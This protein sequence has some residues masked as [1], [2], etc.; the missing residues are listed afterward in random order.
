LQTR[1][2]LVVLFPRAFGDRH[3]E[4]AHL[5]V[6]KPG[7]ATM[8]TVLVVEKKPVIGSLLRER[9]VSESVSVDCVC[10]IDEAVE[11][12]QEAG[13]DVLI[14]NV[15]ASKTERSKG[16]E[17]LDKLTQNSSRTYI[18]AV[19]DRWASPT[20]LNRIRG[21]AH[22]TLTHPLSGDEIHALVMQAFS[23]EPSSEAMKAPE[24]A[25]PLEF[26]GMLGV[27]LPMQ[28]VF[29]RII[30]AASEDISVLITGETG[31][32][33]DMVAS[34]IHRSSRRAA[35]PYVAVNTGAIPSDLI[36][37]ELFGRER[38]AYTGADESAKGHFEQAHGGT[39][40]LD[41]ISTI[42]EKA[43]VS[44]LRVLESKTF[45]RVGGDKDICANVRVI[46]A[47]NEN[48]EAAV[49]DRRF[50]ED[51][52]YRLDVFHIH[53]PPLRER[54]GGVAL[55]TN[56]FVPH[57][58]AIYKK[59]VR[60]IAPETWPCLRNYSWTGNVRELKNVIQR[61]VLM[62]RG[63][64]LTP[65]LLPLR[66]RGASSMQRTLADKIG[67]IHVGMTLNRVE[68]EFIVMTLTATQG[69]KKEAAEQLGISRR[70]LYD[71]L[72]KHELL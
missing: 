44:L 46:A 66:I 43:Q 21:Y 5:S 71:K 41:E 29:R 60:S 16:L 27:S 54:P 23:Q 53:V 22:R 72:R 59:N 33:K 56:H 2:L 28:D 13:Y 14:W 40:F 58:S 68:R 57:F 42:N 31:T 62:A 30:E 34:A 8:P 47:T 35:G 65:D 7:L 48:L 37:S 6:E 9:F 32:G 4:V 52:Y 39:I 45:R 63:H 10:C 61:A 26:E 12:F 24:P 1:I 15:A 50:R 49:H 38:G 67:S 18:I 51:L 11:N 70:A 19:T 17:L 25:M 69:N 20:E 64:E 36:A 3:N 55:L